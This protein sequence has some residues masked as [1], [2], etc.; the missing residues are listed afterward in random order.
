MS[1][2]HCR[3][4]RVLKNALFALDLTLIAFHGTNPFSQTQVDE[5]ISRKLLHFYNAT[6]P[7]TEGW[8]ARLAPWTS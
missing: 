7:A 8:H 4:I 6:S 5:R 1:Y 2:A 3:N